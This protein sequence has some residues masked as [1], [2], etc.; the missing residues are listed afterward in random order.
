MTPVEESVVVIEGEEVSIKTNTIT[1]E[2]NFRNV[3]SLHDFYTPLMA[4]LERFI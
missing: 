3:M 1:P 2:K 4:V